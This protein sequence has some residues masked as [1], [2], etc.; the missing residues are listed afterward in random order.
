MPSF[1]DELFFSQLSKFQRNYSKS[2][3]LRL[4]TYDV[5]PGYLNILQSLWER[6]NITQKELNALIE[7]EQATLSKT[8]S[9]MERDGLIKRN[10][11]PKDR[12]QIHI[13]LSDKARYIQGAVKSAIEDLQSIVNQGLTINDKRYFNRL[14]KQMTEQLENDLSE[15]CLVLFDEISD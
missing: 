13:T 2:L 12:R 1:N 15:P 8:L 3:T 4:E 5:R 7:I 11:N 9:R 14:M 10:P 6:D